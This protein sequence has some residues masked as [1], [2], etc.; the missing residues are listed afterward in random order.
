M[1]QQNIKSRE[2]ES[3]RSASAQSPPQELVDRLAGLLPEEALQ[4]ALKGLGP[5]EITG[6]G[7]LLTQL[8]GRVIEPR[9]MPS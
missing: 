7:G 2:R 8:A 1:S 6:P 4:D 3:S 9:W 5:D